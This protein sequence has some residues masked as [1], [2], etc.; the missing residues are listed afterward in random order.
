MK[1]I[2]QIRGWVIPQKERRL[3]NLLSMH[4]RE[5]EHEFVT[6]SPGLPRKRAARIQVEFAREDLSEFEVLIQMLMQPGSPAH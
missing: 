6:K 3:L 5:R 2:G 4:T 1:K